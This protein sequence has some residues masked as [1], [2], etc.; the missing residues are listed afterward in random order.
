[1]TAE[2][3]SGMWF[4]DEPFASRMQGIILPRLVAGKDPIPAHLN[5]V[6]TRLRYEISPYDEKGGWNEDRWY[7]R[8]FLRTGGGD[9]A[10][11]PVEGTMS[12]YGFCGYGNERIA[13]V[14]QEADRE[15]EVKA[16]VL[17]LDTPGGTVDSTD[18]LADSIRNFSKP[19]IAW[20]NYCASAGYF[21]ASQC[22][23]I[24]LENSIS[25]EVGS[26]GV[27]MV[28]VDQ[29]AAL[30]RE[31]LAVTIFRAKGSHEKAL[32]NGIEPL[33]AE[34]EKQIQ[35]DLNEA[36]VAF[37]GYV[38]RGRAGKL[39]SDYVLTGRMFKKKAALKEGLVD[40]L[41]TLGD[42]ITLARKKAV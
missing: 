39:K 26:I 22:D 12:R 2:T 16:V 23:E 41:G 31:G 5:Q 37:H 21:V 29:S 6:S 11:I 18:M 20:T 28:Y 14:L 36:M 33:T 10:V 25:S 32:I 7:L 17:K 3:F 34:L 35:T 38:R 24:M 1:M 15:P 19:I 9:V 27:L 42:A 40:R 30:E 8:N 13:S 4:I